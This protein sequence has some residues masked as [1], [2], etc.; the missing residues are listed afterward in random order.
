MPCARSRSIVVVRDQIV[1]L[2]LCLM[3][4]CRNGRE[5]QVRRMSGQILLSVPAGGI[6]HPSLA[7]RLGQSPSLVC[8]L[9]AWQA[10]TG[11]AEF[12]SN[13]LCRGRAELKV[14]LEDIPPEGLDLSFSDT[15]LGPADL[16]AQVREIL[17]APKAE[18][19][20]ERTGELVDLRGKYSVRLLLEC[21][22][23]LEPVEIEVEGPLRVVYQ[24]QPTGLDGEE[25][26]LADDDLEVSFYKGE[27][28][29]L[30]LGLYDEVA[31]TIPMAPL[32]KDDCP[33]L[34]PACGK[35]RLEGDCGCLDKK[36]DPRWAKL[37]KLKIK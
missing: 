2:T 11:G 14:L 17:D 26:E 22:R 18:V 28:I 7:P 20:I 6:L 29:D 3:K 23:C 15:K 1:N 12:Y 4:Y 30:S 35:S 37:A 34:C 24:P 16:G 33:G 9:D 27:E 13:L 5:C 21:S 31:L 10:L 36:V 8:Y 32:C 25:I 19:H